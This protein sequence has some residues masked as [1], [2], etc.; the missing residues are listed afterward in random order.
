MKFVL[1]YQ[2]VIRFLLVA[3][4]YN[5]LAY[6]VYAILVFVQINCLVAS[7]ISFFLGISISYLL[8]KTLVFS[9][10]KR[11]SS[12]IVLGYCIYYSLLLSINLSMIFGLTHYLKLNPYI[13]QV[14]VMILGA[15]IS[16]NALSLLF[17]REVQWDT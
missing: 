3:G 16:Y 15:L 6:V 12:Q 7:T 5:L 14:V 4:L 11:H 8:N 10:K 1:N 2:K 13:A 9:N 17:S